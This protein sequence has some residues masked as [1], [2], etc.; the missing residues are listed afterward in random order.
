VHNEVKD[1]R[2]GEVI[3][4]V[5]WLTG[6][7]KTHVGQAGERLV[8]ALETNHFSR[9][10]EAAA[11]HKGALTCAQAGYNPWG[12]VWLFENFEKADTGGR[13]EVLSDHPAD[14]HRIRNL[15]KEFAADPALFG[16]FSP[17]IASATALPGVTA[18]AP[19]P[20]RR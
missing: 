12:M 13:L 8:Y 11:D 2:T 3:G 1:E 19:G 17:D 7:G 16:A 10:V 5:G 18:T 9:E 6:L 14:R 20:P 4:F 15:K